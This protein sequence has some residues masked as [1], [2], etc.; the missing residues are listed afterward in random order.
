MIT[1]L[2]AGALGRPLGYLAGMA[3]GKYE[4]SGPL[5]LTRGLITGMRS[6]N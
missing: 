6:Q 5:D 1:S 2:P 3:D 4:P